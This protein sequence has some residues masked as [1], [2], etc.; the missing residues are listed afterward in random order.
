[1]Q[2]SFSPE[3]SCRTK[4]SDQHLIWRASN[5]RP[6]YPMM[7]DP[8]TLMFCIVHIMFLWTQ[9]H[10]C[11]LIKINAAAWFLMIHCNAI[12]HTYYKE[13]D[14]HYY[15]VPWQHNMVVQQGDFSMWTEE[16]STVF[17]PQFTGWSSVSVPTY[18]L[19]LSSSYQY[20]YWFNFSIP[21]QISYQCHL[22]RQQ[23]QVGS[24]MVA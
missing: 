20:H 24:T 16:M 3:G 6:P 4:D 18:I 12:I 19:A 9:L 23:N 2:V 14:E 8:H 22:Q 21:L 11:I 10:V 15:W 17:I 13:F 5:I 1:M 7:T